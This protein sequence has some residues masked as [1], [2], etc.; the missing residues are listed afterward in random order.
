M[1]AGMW[2]FKV[3]EDKQMA[4]YMFE[5]ITNSEIIKKEFNEHK[6]DVTDQVY[7]RDRIFKYALNSS[8]IHDSYV[9]CNESEPW[10][11]KRI[12]DCYVGCIHC[13]CQKGS[14][15]H[16]QIEPAYK[17]REECRP[18]QHKDWLTC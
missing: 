3:S 4:S 1:M 15:D 11:T 12:D 6:K 18:E 14:Q 2:G 10:P 7:L 9:F 5:T 17:C 8:I 16:S 13:D